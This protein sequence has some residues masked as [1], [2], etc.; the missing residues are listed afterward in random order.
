M[1]DAGPSADDLTH[2]VHA[3]LTLRKDLDAVAIAEALWLASGVSGGGAASEAVTSP[4]ADSAAPPEDSA[5]TGPGDDGGPDSV[6]SRPPARRPGRSADGR[7]VVAGRLVRVGA[8]TAFPMRLELE[9]SL[10]PFK[11]RWPHGGRLRFDLDATVHAYT[12]TGQLVPV[13]RHGAERWFDVAVVRDDAPSMAIWASE[14]SGLSQVLR[15]AGTFRT[16]RDFRLSMSGLDGSAEPFPGL[17]TEAGL[18]CR[19]GHLRAPD[20]RRLIVVVTDGAAPGWRRPEIWQIIRTW[21]AATPTV[22][23]SPLATRMWR[24]TGLDQPAVHIGPGAPGSPNAR[25]KFSVPFFLREPEQGRQDWLPV[26]AVTLSPNRLRSWAGTLMRGDPAGCEALLVPLAGRADDEDDIELP[27]DRDGVNAFLRLSSVPAARLAILCSPFQ[28]VSLPLLRRIRQDLVPTAV[29][30]DV[31]EVLLSGLFLPPE[32][33]PDG[34]EF[35]FHDEARVV[36]R[37]RLAE[38]DVWRVYDMLRSHIADGEDGA[39]TIG[40]FTA[41]VR[42]PDGDVAVPSG[43]RTVSNAARDFR[44]FLAVL[45][46]A[47]PVIEAEPSLV[48]NTDDVSVSLKATAAITVQAH[49]FLT[50]EAGDPITDEA[51]D[52][53]I[54]GSASRGRASVVVVG[55][56]PPQ[57]PN[58]QVRG[59][60]QAQLRAAGPGV[61][62]VRA[63][64]GMR[65]VGKTQLAAAYARECISEGWRLVAWVNASDEEHLLTGLAEVA[66]A[67]QVASTAA[68]SEDAA[69]QLRTWL[70][71]DG[72]RCLVVFD[73]LADLDLLL[74]WLPTSGGAQVLITTTF[75]PALLPGRSVPVDVFA[76]EEAVAFLTEHTGQYDIA[77]ASAVAGELGNLPLALA[78]AAAVIAAQH[79]TYQDYLERLRVLPGRQYLSPTSGDAYPHRIAEAVLLSMDAVGSKANGDLGIALLNIMALLAESG[80]SRVLLHSLA[81][82]EPLHEVAASHAVTPKLVDGALARLGE[83][84]LLS[85]SRDGMKLHA[86]R[87]IM[88]IVRENLQEAGR[89]LDMIRVATDVLITRTEQLHD[90]SDRAAIREI[91]EQVTALLAHAGDAYETDSALTDRVFYL[92]SWALYYLSELGE[93]WLQAVATGESL[94]S[95]LTRLRGADHRSSLAVLSAL[96]NAY[97]A[98]GRINEAAE[99]RE[100]LLADFER[101]MGPE[102]PDT[103]QARGNLAITYQALGRFDEAV[104]LSERTLADFERALE[105]SHALTLAAQNNLARAY[106][107]AGRVGDAIPLL[108]RTLVERER[109]LGLT[110]PDTLI[111][112]NNLA[113]AYQQTGHPGDAIPL[114]TQT[115][116][117]RDRLLGPDHSDTLAS[118][119]NLA[120]A[121]REVGQPAEALPLLEQV[122]TARERLLGPDYPE[123]LDTLN[124]LA[125]TLQDLGRPT[126]ALPLLERALTGS[127]RSFGEDHPSTL[128]TLNNL[129]STLRAVGRSNEALPYLERSVAGLERILGPRHPDTALVR[130]NLDGARHE[131]LSRE[132]NP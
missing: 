68:T 82:T 117:D 112:R 6:P 123:T 44:Q 43:L 58:F 118:R 12:R 108:E 72:D 84:A 90:Q 114:L 27:I 51:G 131:A 54:T 66:D 40:T 128:I 52:P 100:R 38:S 83:L 5:D 106:Q 8:A 4:V 88:R 70:T 15:Q 26:P 81:Y 97:F 50:D 35:S 59:D 80:V 60:L 103:I 21:A 45:P 107:D 37:E 42:D 65:G 11:R 55:D 31:A 22:L 87:L 89:L 18:P 32:T 29:T 110:H 1:P 126:E 98:V 3:A 115:L 34:P 127:D 19:P 92:R 2:C 56:V 85:P 53:I 104:A 20:G 48:T 67:L 109:S 113:V 120:T 30:E 64:T 105:P 94:A 122:L 57:P 111:S 41:A 25:L 28:S 69:Q 96:A 116:A 125:I 78:Q 86:H 62:V 63:V 10:L 95:D 101:T 49:T 9:R 17:T 77:G 47:I 13:F 7:T 129:A 33:G 71:A 93:S 61:S 24:Q 39:G 76:P 23:V 99:L 91:P 79:L 75:A 132:G 74:P 36:L 119:N 14:V 124:N 46:G 73:D 130:E 121:L 102:Q 16:V